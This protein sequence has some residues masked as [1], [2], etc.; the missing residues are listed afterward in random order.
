MQYIGYYYSPLGEI[1]LAGKEDALTGLW[2]KGQKYFGAGL[3][4]VCEKGESPLFK[5]VRQWLD[6]Y[7]SGKN[8]GCIPNVCTEGWSPFRRRVWEVLCEIPYGQTVT[9]GEIADLLNKQSTGRNIS[10]RA[11]GGAV[12]HNPISIIIPCHRV[13]GKNGALT[14]Y[15]GGLEKKNF[16]LQLERNNSFC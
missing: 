12:G 6:T 10:V 13:V 14:G 5:D 8:P 3:A 9:Y 11:I 2:F 16:L 7:F 1:T 4:D 15:A